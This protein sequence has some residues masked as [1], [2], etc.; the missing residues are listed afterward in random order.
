MTRE[1]TTILKARAGAATGFLQEH[2][3]QPLR[4]SEAEAPGVADAINHLLASKGFALN[5]F[6]SCITYT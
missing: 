1:Y 5:P 3:I 6:M 2:L 4:E